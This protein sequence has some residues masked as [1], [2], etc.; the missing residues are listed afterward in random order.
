MRI[1][2][3]VHKGRKLLSPPARSAARPITGRAKKSLFEMLGE[4]LAA[5]T[6]LDLYCGT[7]TLGLEAISRGAGRCFFADRDDA[8][9]DRLRR[10]IAALGV[11][12][13]AEIWRGDVMADLAGWLGRLD[14]AIDVAFIDPPYRQTRRW[15]WQA[16]A[17]RIF[18]PLADR[19]ADDGLLVLRT[20]TKTDLPPTAGPLLVRRTRS[21]GDMV[22]VLLGRAE[23]GE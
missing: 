8:V 12:E 3:G 4:Q 13:K 19:L 6:V 5:G 1:L 17:D 7:G 9:L 21:F 15:D 20:P 23:E 18:S 11:A 10:N 14:G 2:A 16:A 22:I